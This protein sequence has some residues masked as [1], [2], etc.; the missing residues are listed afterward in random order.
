M[1]NWKEEEIL[2]TK[3]FFFI[4]SN[5]AGLCKDSTKYSNVEDALEITLLLLLKKLDVNKSNS[6]RPLKKELKIL[7]L[8]NETKP[9]KKKKGK[10]KEEKKRGAKKF[11]SKN[12][13]KN[14]GEKIRHQHRCVLV[15]LNVYTNYALYL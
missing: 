1:F 5:V 7:K 9:T 14:V 11:E 8:K 15:C 3:F 2:E 6:E 4:E 10:K 12:F 13:L